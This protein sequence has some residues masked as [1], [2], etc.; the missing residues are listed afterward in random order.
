M[1]EIMSHQDKVNIAREGRRDRF[2][3]KPEP[4]AAGVIGFTQFLIDRMK[5]CGENFCPAED[6][7]PID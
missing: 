3:I 7:E 1:S 4:Y 2:E 5:S 6:A